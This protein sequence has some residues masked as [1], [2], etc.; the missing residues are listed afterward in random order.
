MHAHTH[1]CTL[2]LLNA[3]HFPRDAWEKWR[4]RRRK[5][6]LLHK[7]RSGSFENLNVSRK[8]MVDSGQSS[9]EGVGWPGPTFYFSPLRV[10]NKFV[11]KI[12]EWGS[13]KWVRDGESKCGHK[14]F[15]RSTP[16]PVVSAKTWESIY[17]FFRFRLKIQ[18]DM[19]QQTDE[20]DESFGRWWFCVSVCK[21]VCVCVHAH[22]CVALWMW[23]RPCTTISGERKIGHRPEDILKLLDLKSI[24]LKNPGFTFLIKSL[25]GAWIR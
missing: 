5:T 1:T 9:Q 12:T 24:K 7:R 20:K 21:C 19:K 22:V 14:W 13:L 2:S 10:L 17:S 3:A 23:E 4:N 16:R 15:V 11:C 18:F 6:Y 25:V 8:W